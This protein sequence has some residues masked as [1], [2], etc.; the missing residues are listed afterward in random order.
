MSFPTIVYKDKGPH[1]RKGG[2]YDYKG[3][4]DQE[5]LDA[6]IEAGWHT[7]LP[8]ATG[9][10]VSV[11]ADF[12]RLKSEIETLGDNEPPTRAELEH[13]AKELGIKFSKKMTD[14]E[15]AKLIDV[16]LGS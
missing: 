14:A 7:T 13:Q 2:T 15:L 1:Q 11:A 16:E 5:E 3:V 9:E 6:A 12:D 4:A 8:A 10:V